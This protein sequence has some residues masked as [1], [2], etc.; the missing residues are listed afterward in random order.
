MRRTGGKALS[1]LGNR[2]SLSLPPSDM[3]V[4]L[5]MQRQSHSSATAWHKHQPLGNQ[6]HLGTF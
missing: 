3:C 6:L 5:G 2:S 4:P 1:D